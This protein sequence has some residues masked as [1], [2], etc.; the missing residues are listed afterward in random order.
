MKQV[1]TRT[2]KMTSIAITIQTTRHSSYVIN[3]PHVH[4]V[5]S[6]VVDSVI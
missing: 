1:R 4:D 5:E 2:Q 3:T 6:H